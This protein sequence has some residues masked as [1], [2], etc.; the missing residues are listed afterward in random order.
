MTDPISLGHRQARDEANARGKHWHADDLFCRPSLETRRRAVMAD[1]VKCQH[2]LDRTCNWR[3][4]GQLR[5]LEGPCDCL[6]LAAE[7]AWSM[8]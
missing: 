7:E 6:R 8:A 1:H 5:N 3:R 2:Y 4:R